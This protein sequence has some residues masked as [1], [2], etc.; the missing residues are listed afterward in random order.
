LNLVPDA[1]HGADADL[2]GLR[3]S[4]TSRGECL[5]PQA[6]TLTSWHLVPEGNSDCQARP[7]Q[8]QEDRHFLVVQLHRSC[9]LSAVQRLRI[10]HTSDRG[11]TDVQRIRSAAEVTRYNPNHAYTVA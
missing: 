5:H 2:A 7:G 6:K 3:L 8:V 11:A 4:R 10:R 9:S 1:M